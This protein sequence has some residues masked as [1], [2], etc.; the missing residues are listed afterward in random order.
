MVDLEPVA[1]LPVDVCVSHV[2]DVA[3][4][5]LAGPLDLAGAPFVSGADGRIRRVFGLA[6]ADERVRFAPDIRAAL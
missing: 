2:G 5:S 3:V 6:G 1:E 4:V